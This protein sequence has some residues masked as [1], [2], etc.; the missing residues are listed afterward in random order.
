MIFLC[1]SCGVV[2]GCSLVFLKICGEIVNSPEAHN[3]VLFTVLMGALGGL[4]AVFNVYALNQSMKYYQNLD[5]MP[6]YQSFILMHMILSGLIVLN[7]AALY[8]VWELVKLSGSAVL[9]IAGIYV[10]TQKKNMV[11]VHDQE[12]ALA[13]GNTQTFYVS[14]Q[15][16][17]ALNEYRLSRRSQVQQ[18]RDP[19]LE[20]SLL[21][22][23]AIEGSIKDDS[24]EFTEN[25]Y[26]KL[27]ENVFEDDAFAL[28]SQLVL[29]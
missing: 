20:Q 6:A 24:F 1:W 25:Y 13:Q 16:Q 17:M 10:L 3:H 7:E 23:D 27:I 29:R 5:V 9:V 19:N 26:R 15:L 28:D 2:N 21:P 14:N 11:V 4:C 12:D 8:S 22:D 18:T